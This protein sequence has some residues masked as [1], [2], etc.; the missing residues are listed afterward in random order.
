MRITAPQ[1]VSRLCGCVLALTLPVTSAACGNATPATTPPR[2][3]AHPS[4]PAQS[5]ESD[6]TGT[7]T[8]TMTVNGH[9]FT[10]TT[11]DNATARAFIRMLPLDDMR[12]SEL[13]HKE[14]YARLS[15]DLPT[16]H[17]EPSTIHSGDVMLYQNDVLVV[18]YQTHR[19]EGYSY[20]R[21][22]T[23]DNVEGLEEAVGPDTATM[24]FRKKG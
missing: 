7:D 21:I 19:N 24:A 9:A 1:T 12:M 11:A 13:A 8:I 20:T 2:A 15:H 3:T 22:G 17:S 4:M 6:T 23:I 14:K 10:L 16:E 5:T 18:F